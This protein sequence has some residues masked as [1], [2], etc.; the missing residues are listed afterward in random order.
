MFQKL[1]YLIAIFNQSGYIIDNKKVFCYEPGH[2]CCQ[3]MDIYQANMTCNEDMCFNVTINSQ[4]H[5][6]IEK[7]LS[8]YPSTGSKDMYN[9][10]LKNGSELGFPEYS[11]NLMTFQTIKGYDNNMRYNI[12]E[13][14]CFKS[15]W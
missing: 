8:V 2:P 6:Q 11:S 15:S 5:P 3:N 14:L 12:K 7:I 10:Y 1:F 4:S 13:Q 9:S